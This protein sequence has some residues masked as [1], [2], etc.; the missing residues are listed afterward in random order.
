MYDKFII[1]SKFADKF[2]EMK[3]GLVETRHVLT[4]YLSHPITAPPWR[5]ILTQRPAHVVLF[6]SFS[7]KAEVLLAGFPGN[8]TLSAAYCEKNDT[9]AGE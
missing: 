9:P 1:Y 3:L 6:V 5:H 8:A 7:L 2:N 4:A